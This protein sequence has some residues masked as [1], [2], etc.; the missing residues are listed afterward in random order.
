[1]ARRRGPKE[2]VCCPVYMTSPDERSDATWLIA[3]TVGYPA[4]E[5]EAASEAAI[6]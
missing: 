2:K 6:S 1:M 4:S 3:Q 5:F